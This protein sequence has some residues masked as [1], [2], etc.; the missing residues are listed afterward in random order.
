MQRLD[1]AIKVPITNGVA[2]DFYMFCAFMKGQI[3]SDGLERGIPKSC[4]K[5]SNHDTSQAACVITRYSDS[6]EER[7]TTF[8]FLE[9]QEMRDVPRNKQNPET[10]RR[11]S[12]QEA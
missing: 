1:Q 12:E 7:E 8:C 6:A 5:T 11:V 9:R 4:S 2:V 10:D 3:W